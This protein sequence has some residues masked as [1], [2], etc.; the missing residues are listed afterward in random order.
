MVYAAFISVRLPLE[1]V[2]LRVDR[3]E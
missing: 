2:L 3:T 1:L